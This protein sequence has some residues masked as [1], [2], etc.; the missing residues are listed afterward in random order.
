MQ[1]FRGNLILCQLLRL[2]WFTLKWTWYTDAFSIICS[3]QTSL[4]VQIPQWCGGL[5]G[6]TVFVDT[7]GSFI[8]KRLH[9]MAVEL[10]NHCQN[11]IAPCLRHYMDGLGKFLMFEVLHLFEITY[12]F[13]INLITRSILCVSSKNTSSGL[14][15]A[16]VTTW[17][18]SNFVLD[19]LNLI[20]RTLIG[21]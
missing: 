18:Q 9:Q 13:L 16:L 11:I 6:E 2:T 4:T 19:S 12:F 3:L 21:W 20:L 1:N 5:D 15:E 10:V 7:E 14:S 17:L 8:P